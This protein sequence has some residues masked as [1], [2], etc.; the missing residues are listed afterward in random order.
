MDDTVIENMRARVA[1]CR[2]LANMTHNPEIIRV[3]TEMADQGETDIRKL[4]EA[5]KEGR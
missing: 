3:L 4:E 2:R 1:H 5:A